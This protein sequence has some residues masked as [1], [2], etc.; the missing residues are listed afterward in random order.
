MT[1]WLVLHYHLGVLILADTLAAGSAALGLDEQ[2]SIANH[3]LASTRAVVNVINLVRQFD[4]FNPDKS[5]LL[6]RDPYPEHASSCLHR[7]AKSVVGLIR[8]GSIT[9]VIAAVLASALLQGLQI[10]SQISF[11]ASESLSALAT[12]F[13]EHGIPLNA[14]DTSQQAHTEAASSILLDSS[15]TPEMLENETLKEL[16]H[17]AEA[18]PALVLKSIERHEIETPSP[19]FGL[20]YLQFIDFTAVA[21]DWDFEDCFA[22]G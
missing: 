9:T 20:G 4:N 17:Q 14:K 1:V 3:R 2:V 15:V 18:D 21:G 10:V 7:A 5:S 6:L 8:S 16:G 11:S 19:T 12:L 22:G 13:Q